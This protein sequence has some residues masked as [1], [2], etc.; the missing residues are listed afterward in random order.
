M[1][2]EASCASAKYAKYGGGIHAV[3][4]RLGQGPGV[5]DN[6]RLAWPS[7]LLHQ[8]FLEPRRE[9]VRNEIASSSYPRMLTSLSVTI[10]D[11]RHNGSYARMAI[12]TI[13][14]PQC[15]TK[16]P[17]GVRT[18]CRHTSQGS[19]GL[20]RNNN[21][22]ME[23]IWYMGMNARTLKW[24]VGLDGVGVNPKSQRLCHGLA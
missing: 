12:P 1:P 16:T 23:N 7:F 5:A 22:V 15:V 8:P 17:S 6:K 10:I 11:T 14:I 2:A 24:F 3:S 20:I 18:Q 4:Y 19:Q 21:G 13:K 9:L